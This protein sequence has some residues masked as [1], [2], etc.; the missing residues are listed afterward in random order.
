MSFYK[1][2]STG[3]CPHC[4]HDVKFINAE[5]EDWGGVVHGGVS[6]WM[7]A[8]GKEDSII[9][10]S[11]LCPNC[12]KLV[13]AMEVHKKGSA[14]ILERRLVFPPNIV[15]VAPPEVPPYIREDFLESAAVLSISEKA[16]AA[17]SRRCLQNILN[18]KVG[19]KR[20]LSTQI[21]E[22]IKELPT[23][24]GENLDAIRQVGNY[25]SHPMKTQSTGTIIDVEPEEA[26]WTLDVLEEL[27]DY[28]YVMPE[29]AARRRK[30]L[31]K[32]LKSIGKPPMKK[33]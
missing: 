24:I 12:K 15:R 11:S 6:T 21:D 9:V 14:T 3:K 5:N 23:R 16:S 26:N 27:F 31:D 10:Y 30:K 2:Y 8:T 33:P 18:E 22:A 4:R 17:L 29:R 19:K 32:K 7:N 13:V 1:L 28:Y 20:D 25:G